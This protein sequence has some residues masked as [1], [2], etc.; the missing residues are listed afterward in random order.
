MTELY[1]GIPIGN[2]GMENSMNIANSND[3]PADPTVGLMILDSNAK[4]IYA[5]RNAERLI[6]GNQQMSEGM[7]LETSIPT[8]GQVEFMAHDKDEKTPVPV[9]I[10]CETFDTNGDNFRVLT[11][12]RKEPVSTCVDS[13]DLTERSLGSVFSGMLESILIID[14]T[15]GKIVWSNPYSAR[16]LGFENGCL[17]GRPF[18]DLFPPGSEIQAENV[19]TEVV[20]AD[21]VFVTQ[22]FLRGDGGISYMDLTASLIPWDVDSTAILVVLRD[23]SERKQFEELRLETARLNSF[24]ELSA[25]VAHHFNN[26]LQVIIGFAGLAQLELE[27][28]RSS[29]I[30]PKLDQII[31]SSNEAANAIRSLQDF[32]R[33]G[34]PQSCV[35]SEVVNLNTLA[36]RAANLG[37][38][39]WKTQPVGR[40]TAVSIET[41][42]TQDCYARVNQE[43]ILEVMINLIKNGVE[44]IVE[45]GTVTVG[46]E[47]RGSDAAFYVKD[48]GA[49]IKLEDL[50]RIFDPFWTTK[51]PKK[52]GL[53]LASALGI[54]KQNDGEIK[55]ETTDGGGTAFEVIFPSADFSPD[56]KIPASTTSNVRKISVL[57]VDEE[58]KVLELLSN[59]LELEGYSVNSA[60][61]VAEG[62]RIVDESDV[63]LVV[64]DSGSHD[65]SGWDLGRLLQDRYQN[66]DKGKPSLILLTAWGV[67]QIQNEK[68]RRAGVDAILAKPVPIRDLVAKIREII[69]QK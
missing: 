49:G 54:V 18:S 63:D 61:T 10:L 57:V 5:N 48:T 21:G 52:S 3:A 40:E 38:Q 15:N 41:D 53:G 14:S 11:I 51:G 47:N 43:R 37:K 39:W 55:V 35:T 67:G 58:E 7:T 33:C 68:I 20:C 44:S 23:A 24:S 56:T 1:I 34:Q 29:R 46:V 50:R 27:S 2:S 12:S 31:A 60:S 19:L 59:G 64:S 9:T 30:K 17:A 32:A 36:R 69:S 22:T 65:M 45:K 4:I 26:M 28:G 25:G 66:S 16:S 6:I 8:S 42:L 13:S 62:L